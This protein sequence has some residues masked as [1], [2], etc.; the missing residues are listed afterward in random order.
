M[1]KKQY[2]APKLNQVGK[3]K[4]LTL[5]GGSKAADNFGRKNNNGN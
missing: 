2:T 3:V 5:S 1:K 4:N